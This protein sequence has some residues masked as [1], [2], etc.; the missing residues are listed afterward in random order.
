M[1]LARGF[2]SGLVLATGPECIIN[3]LCDIAW[4]E[5][6]FRDGC[7]SICLRVAIC[8]LVWAARNF[9]NGRVVS[10]TWETIIASS[11]LQLLWEGYV[12]FVF[13]CVHAV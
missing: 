11:G 7:S 5:K 8:A 6:S 2:L 3:I 10:C 4:E 1:S 9:G 13:F 12:F